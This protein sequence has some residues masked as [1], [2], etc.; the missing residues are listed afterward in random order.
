MS[1]DENKELIDL[2]RVVARRFRGAMNEQVLMHEASLTGFQ[3]R[4][5]NLIGRSKEISQLLLT[6]F[7]ESDKAQIA[8]AL[9]DLELRGLIKRNADKRDSRV[10]IL[11]LTSDG[12][13]IYA[14]LNQS[15][16]SIASLAFMGLNADEKETL[17][18]CLKKIKTALET[19]S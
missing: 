1:T 3:G 4:L 10:K 7:T 2:L 5:I 18:S 11:S 9:K 13:R 6:Q 12:E 17:S 14:D 15:H 8:R 16:A 19:H